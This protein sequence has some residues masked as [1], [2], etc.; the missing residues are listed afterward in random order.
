MEEWTVCSCYSHKLAFIANRHSHVCNVSNIQTIDF[1]F[2]IKQD[3]PPQKKNW[4]DPYF[5]YGSA[6]CWI[7]SLLF[8]FAEWSDRPHT[9]RYFICYWVQQNE[10]EKEIQNRRGRRD[11]II[12]CETSYM[13]HV[14]VVDLI[15]LIRLCIVCHLSEKRKARARAHIFSVQSSIESYRLV[16]SI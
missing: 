13:L 16:S 12:E 11:R 9:R 8:N 5:R 4:N 7:S 1:P 3:L 6:M 14:N 2:A 15:S 10:I